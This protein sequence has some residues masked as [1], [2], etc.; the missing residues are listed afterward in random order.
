MGKNALSPLATLALIWLL[1][2]K[3][4]KGSRAAL[5][6]SLRSFFEHRLTGTAWAEALEGEL[7]QLAGRG[8]IRSEGEALA[9]TGGGRQA[10]LELLGLRRL[11]PKANFGDLHKKYVVPR[12]AAS[13]RGVALSAAELA[14]LGDAKR[15]GAFVTANARGLHLNTPLPTRTQLRD[16][17][18]WQAL[19]FERRDEL[20]LAKLVQALLSQLA[21]AEHA[22]SAEQ[23]LDRLVA[24]AVGARRTGADEVR[25]AVVRAWVDS[26]A[27]ASK[28]GKGT[29][30]AGALTAVR[31]APEPARGQGARRPGAIVRAASSGEDTVRG[32]GSGPPD[33]VPGAADG[34]GGGALSLQGFAERVVREARRTREGRFGERKVFISHLARRVAPLFDLDERSFKAKLVEA[35]RAGLLTLSRADL[36]GAMSPE[37]VAASETTY[38]GATFHFVVAEPATAP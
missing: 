29:P 35:H 36:V 11:P 21:G 26:D 7:G 5:E 25:A 18:V 3:G 23:A 10:A 16:A 32:V 28:P 2:R 17:L 13:A 15:L 1:P 24:Q 19:G 8:L 4:A 34:G 38:L 22:R 37:A 6:R 27:T 9:L 12:A 14:K 31:K 33:G 30:K 20:S